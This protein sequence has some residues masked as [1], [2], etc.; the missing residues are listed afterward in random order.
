MANGA[1]HDLGVAEV[2]EAEA[3]GPPGQR[4]FRLRVIAGDQTASIWCEKTQVSALSE[5][6]Q[7]VLAR[8][9]GAG[10]ARRPSARPLEPFPDRASHDFLAGRIALGYDEDADLIT[11]FATDV[12]QEGAGGMSPQPTLRVD[13][14]RQVARQFAVQAEETVAGGRPI[15]PLCQQPLEGSEHLCPRTNGHAE[16]ALAEIGP[17]EL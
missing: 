16:D 4:R 14:S 5:A 10:Q 3:I 7:Q 9:R 15:C 17:P 13:I 11:L 2:L 12:E 6:I 8:N 1:E